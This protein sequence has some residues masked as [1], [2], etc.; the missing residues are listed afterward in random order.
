MYQTEPPQFPVLEI[1]PPPTQ[2]T[3]PYDDD[4]PMETQR[5]KMQM[6]L[7]VDSLYP[8]ITQREGGGYVGG[9]MFVYFSPNQVL[10]QDYKGPDVF[11]VLDVPVK[12]RKSW[13]VW[14]EGKGPDVVI[15]L[16]SPST[17]RHDKTAKK[18]IYQ[19]QLRVPEYVWYDPFNP[20]DFAGFSLQN[21]RYESTPLTENGCFISQQ[22]NLA[23]V[24]WQG[25]FKGVETVWLRWSTLDGELLPTDQEQ[26]AEAQKQA[27]QAN[28]RAELLAAELRRLGIDPD[29]I[30]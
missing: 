26:K 13:V 14:E 19:R 10:N 24:R 20:E 2:D 9:N 6:D 3:L 21:G 28:Q 8:W 25:D 11:A 22:L 5:H 27:E 29:Q 17:A 16:L 1:V 4:E 23:L 7:L 18:Q 15:E 12:E 30:T